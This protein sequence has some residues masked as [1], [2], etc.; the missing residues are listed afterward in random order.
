M[1]IFRDKQAKQSRC[2][3]K[4]NYDGPLKS[5][6]EVEMKHKNTRM[7]EG[8]VPSMIAKFSCVNVFGQWLVIS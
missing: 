7:K 5:E 4:N 6:T 3:H 2:G 8:H 1:Q